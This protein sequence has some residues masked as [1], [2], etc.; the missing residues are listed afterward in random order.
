MSIMRIA[1]VVALIA[2]FV[3]P[4]RAS[5]PLHPTSKWNVD[6]GDANCVAM[7]N[8]GPPDKLITLAFKPSPIG[9]VMQMSVVRAARRNEM[10]QYRGSLTVDQSGPV[11]ISV[12]GYPS[13]DGKLRVSAINLTPSTYTPIRTA[14]TIRIRS[15][16]EVDT[17]FALSQ[18]GEV[19][20]MLDKCMLD[21]RQ[22]WHLGDHSAS[23]KQAAIN[24]QPLSALFSSD[25]Y[26]RVA[27]N[28]DGTGTVQ[29]MLLIN[30]SGRIASCMVT[31]TSG[32]ASLDAQTCIILTRRA[33]FGPAVGLDG[34]PAKS[35]T[36]AR[37]RWKK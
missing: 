24:L 18:M 17:V 7:R 32:F 14:R 36:T 29:V 16:G 5:E 2:L 10:N 1:S 19:A 34:K 12:L 20:R 33:R 37:I 3:A 21:L 23:L 28:N 15:G 26:P 9:D 35:G 31:E 4:V 11:A 22:V 6:F 25:D 13:T 8:Y 30:E 27:L